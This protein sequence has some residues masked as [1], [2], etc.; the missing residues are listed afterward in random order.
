M[1]YF[2]MA[3]SLA[4][5]QDGES[6]GRGNYD[7]ALAELIKVVNRRPPPPRQMELQ[8]IFL[9]VIDGGAIGREV[10]IVREEDEN[11]FFFGEISQAVLDRLLVIR[12][13]QVSSAVPS[14]KIRAAEVETDDGFIL[15]R[16][17]PVLL[18]RFFYFQEFGRRVKQVIEE[19]FAQKRRLE[20]H[21]ITLIV[22]GGDE[23]KEIGRFTIPDFQRAYLDLFSE[24]RERP[25]LFVHGFKISGFGKTGVEIVNTALGSDLA[26]EVI[27][28]KA[29]AHPA[30]RKF[31]YA[32]HI[33][34]F[35]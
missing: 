10:K 16:E 1:D 30:G 14:G 32:Q 17:R 19:D 23:L 26:Q 2:F 5:R 35:A 12:E 21:I 7:L 22:A 28:K 18:V 27:M 8:L 20:D 15:G 29:V 4:G 25:R 11:R 13:F 9:E 31:F 3:P 24:E 6:A 34:L 33:A